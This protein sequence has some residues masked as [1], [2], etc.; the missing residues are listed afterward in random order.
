MYTIQALWSPKVEWSFTITMSGAQYVTTTGPSPR[1]RSSV[2]KWVSPVLMSRSP[3]APS[4]EMNRLIADSIRTVYTYH[5]NHLCTVEM[6]ALLAL[7]EN[8]SESKNHPPSCTVHYITIF[9]L[10]VGMSKM[11]VHNFSRK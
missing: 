2:V 3:S 8:S 1:Q 4:S 7:V 5:G 10:Y 9:E 11:L 6:L